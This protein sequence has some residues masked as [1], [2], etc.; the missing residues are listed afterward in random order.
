MDDLS[1]SFIVSSLIP[2]I[3]PIIFSIHIYY[4]YKKSKR[5]TRKLYPTI[6]LNIVFWFFSYHNLQFLD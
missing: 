4:E 3:I 2:K 1:T 5:I 6:F